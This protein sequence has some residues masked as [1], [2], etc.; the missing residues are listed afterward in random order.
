MTND[1]KKLIEGWYTLAQLVHYNALEKGFWSEAN[2]KSNA[3]QKIALMHEELSE[4]LGAFR[5]VK[6]E[7]SEKIPAF[8]EQEE[9]LA[10]LVI[11]AMDFATH[12]GI[13]LPEAMLAKHTYNLSR[14]VKHGKNF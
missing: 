8:S 14:P 13:R 2:E 11:R 6:P 9:E 7:Q 1:E 4:L 5:K 3:G 10:D 12:Y